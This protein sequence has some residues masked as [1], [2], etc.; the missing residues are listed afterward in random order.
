MY[1]LMLDHSYD[2]RFY[3]DVHAKQAF[4]NEY[5]YESLLLLF[6]FNF[7]PEQVSRLIP[8]I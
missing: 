1:V 8:W 5:L 7:L 4:Y 3:N 6:C 2:H